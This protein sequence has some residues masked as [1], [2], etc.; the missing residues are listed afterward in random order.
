VHAIGLFSHGFGYGSGLPGNVPVINNSAA[1]SLELSPDYTPASKSGLYT[2][3]NV[4][5]GSQLTD[6]LKLYSGDPINVTLSYDGSMLQETLFDTVTS[7]TFTNGYLI[8]LPSVVGGS[9]ALVGFTGGTN[10]SGSFGADQ[11]FSNFNFTSVPEPST[12]A[13]LGVGGIGLLAYV[14]RKRAA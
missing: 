12:I 3:G 7:A 9:T 11:Y 4:G 13:L 2:N 8:N 14:R 10:G 1:I 5:G 6:P